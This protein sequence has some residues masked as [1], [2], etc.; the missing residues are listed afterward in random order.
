MSDKREFIGLFVFIFLALKIDVV[1][2]IFV[3]DTLEVLEVG[4]MGLKKNEPDLCF[5]IAFFY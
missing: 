5:H 2:N 1:I 4:F 3:Q